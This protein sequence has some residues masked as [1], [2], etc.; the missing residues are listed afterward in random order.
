MKYSNTENHAI[1]RV[2]NRE[3]A[4]FSSLL[5]TLGHSA[6]NKSRNTSNF[7]LRANVFYGVIPEKGIS[8]IL[9][10]VGVVLIDPI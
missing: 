1:A 7:I 4:L 5:F 2:N 10:K 6:C 3:D 8:I 9:S